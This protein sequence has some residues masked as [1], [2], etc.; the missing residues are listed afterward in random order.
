[1]SKRGRN[2]SS[3][4][5]LNAIDGATYSD[6]PLEFDEFLQSLAGQAQQSIEQVVVQK[7]G[8]IV[9]F[10]KFEV[11]EV[12]LHING[13][14]SEDEYLAFITGLKRITSALQWIIGDLIAY[15]TSSLGK[16]Y[17]ELSEIFGYSPDTL[18][19]FV[20]VC[21]NIPLNER[22]NGHAK[23]GHH[24][25]VAHVKPAGVRASWLEMVNEK[26]LSVAALRTL[27]D[28]TPDPVSSPLANKTN[29]AAFNRIWRVL[30][31]GQQEIKRKDLE[32]LKRWIAE[33]ERSKTIID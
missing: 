14:L 29:R 1:M 11:S 21:R 24:Q 16:T 30:S 13:E 6:D 5:Q 25:V 33:V 17:E 23:F 26:R 10:G 3:F 7:T 27:V 8:G 4:E 20:R 32:R 12:G 19:E 2:P 18:A 9:A 31:S 28:G 15:G 22:F